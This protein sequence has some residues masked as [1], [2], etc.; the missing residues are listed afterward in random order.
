MTTPHTKAPALWPFP[1]SSDPIGSIGASSGPSPASRPSVP[2]KPRIL[3]RR[4]RNDRMTA[5]DIQDG[6]NALGEAPL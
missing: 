2:Q 6:I 5:A 1:I 3:K 4:R